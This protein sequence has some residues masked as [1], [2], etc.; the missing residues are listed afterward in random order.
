MDGFVQMIGRSVLVLLLVATQT[1]RRAC[2]LHQDDLGMYAADGGILDG[3]VQQLVTDRIDA[4][5][6]NRNAVI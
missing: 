3:R 6:I 1:T 5:K 2:L 4:H